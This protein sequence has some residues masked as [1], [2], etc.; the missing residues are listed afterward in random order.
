MK[1]I[2][3]WQPWASAIALQQKRFETRSWPTKYRGPL[4]IH[5]ATRQNKAD[6]AFFVGMLLKLHEADYERWNEHCDCM[7]SCL[8]YGEIVAVCDL[9]DCV[10]VEDAAPSLFEKLWGDYS[11]GRFAWKLANV[12]ALETPIPATGH[13]GL[14]N[15]D[16]T[17]PEISTV[18]LSLL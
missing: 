7:Y 4:A 2:T 12:R 6:E 14:W 17:A 15:W 3:L 10:L 1:A 11:P 8:P 16:H 18:Q 9:I 5:A 13:Q